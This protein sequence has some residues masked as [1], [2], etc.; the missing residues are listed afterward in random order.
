MATDT[1]ITVESANQRLTEVFA[2]WIRQL[3]IQVTEI[4]GDQVTLRLPYHDDL[5][6]SGGLIC[7]QALMSLIDTCMVFVC[8]LG[9]GRYS[10]C[11][12]VS[13]H[14]TFIRPAIGVD[15]IAT[16]KLVKS[17]RTL[18][19]GEVTLTSDDDPRPVCNGSLTYAVINNK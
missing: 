19:F 4:G 8:Y 1:I 6:R 3:N 17:G 13:Q 15:V 14:T 9:M 11:A 7:G 16:G 18:I 5:C 2:P 10:D 12:T